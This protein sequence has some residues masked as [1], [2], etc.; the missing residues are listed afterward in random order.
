MKHINVQVIAVAAAVLAAASVAAQ[1]PLHVTKAEGE[2]TVAGD[3]FAASWRADR[4]WQIASVQVEDYAGA[5]N[6]GGLRNDIAGLGAVA[7]R[8][9]GNTYLACEGEA[10]APEIV[11]Q[12][13]DRLTF[14]VI[15]RPRAMDGAICPL[16]LAQRFTV[17]GEGAV[18]C[19][20]EV[21]APEDAAE[22]T[23]DGIEVGMTLA[24]DDLAHLRW[25]WKH[26][27]RGE[28][29]LTREATLEDPRYLRVLGT[30]VGRERP[31][32]NQIEM[33]LEER[34]PLAGDSDSGM[35][36]QV[37]DD[38]G[39]NKRFSWLIG[40]P[41]T[42]GP[43][44]TYSNRFGLALGH[45][46][47]ND[48]AIGQ[49]IAHWQEGN[50]N[51][52][53]YPSDSAIEAMA[54]C[55]VTIN[56]LHLYWY[57][58]P[59]YN[60]FDEAD[61]RRWIA[62]CHERGIKC[63]VYA[64]PTDKAGISGINPEWVQ[65]LD[66]DGIY[67]DF[68]ATH[69][70]SERKY[71]MGRDF[72][73]AFPAMATVELTRHFREAVGP[74]GIIISHSGGYAPDAFFHLNLNAYLPGEAGVQGALLTDP[75]GAAYH[76]GMAYAVVHPWCEYEPFQTRHG[77]AAYCAM[78]GFPHIL[79]G[80]GTHQDNN[81]HRSVYR[82]AKFALP[83]WQMLS[84]I[85]MDRETT[86]YTAATSRAAWTDQEPVRCC[87]YLRSPDLALVTASNL[88][89]A[90]E[91]TLSLDAGLLGLSG[92]Y[93]VIRLA[94]PDIEHF[95]ATE[96]GQWS[97]GEIPLGRMATDD[98]MGLLL[99]RGETPEHTAR[100]LARIETLVASFSDEQA[101]TV[102]DGLAAESSPGAVTL[103]WQP[104][105]DDNHVV[106]HRLYRG[107]EG[108]ELEL[109]AETE[110][111]TG[112][113]DYTAP[114][115]EQVSYAVS[116]VDVAGNESARSPVVTIAT[117]GG[118][119]AGDAIE[120]AVG[121]WKADG[122][123][124]RQGTERVPATEAGDTIEFAPRTAQ[125]VRAW[126]TGGLGNHGSAH[127]IEMTVRDAA[128]RAIKPVAVSSIGS[129]PG[130]PDTDAADGITDKESNGWWSDRT[131]SLPAWVAFDLG[132]PREV[133]SVW[134]LTFWDDTRFYDY[135]IQV[136][137]DG[138]EWR[139][140]GTGASPARN[141]RAFADVAFADGTAS[142]TTLETD[143]ERAGG[144]LLFRCSDESNGY[145]LTL[146]PRWD[147]NLV[148][149]KLVDGKLHRLAGAFFPFSIHNPIPHR[150][151]A[152]C[153]GSTIRCYCDGRLVMEVEDETFTS[154]RAGV[155]VP[156]G[157][158]LMFMNLHSAA[159][160]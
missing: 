34:K 128:G 29:D 73:R 15:A 129:D 148:L 149:D 131:K 1:Q 83:Y 150:L 22:V 26:T 89:E 25:H 45:L 124:L 82:A 123:W 120:P 99:V 52:M 68:G 54:E 86:L 65:G 78:G 76:S 47:Q 14:E 140:V 156:S 17:F 117:A 10:T 118:A 81:Y 96:V 135:S 88:G 90:C 104:A 134:L 59:A 112:Y 119:L 102:P 5:W 43:G 37:S 122:S 67:F 132:G 60:V 28:Q 136:S 144:G 71:D 116:A 87:V 61:M 74:E 106:E 121:V 100:Q 40:G 75:R 44:F 147:G 39:G 158:R 94:G 24:T 95:A 48:N 66:L 103:D 36:C 49:R 97:G 107:F 50:A 143:P 63:I 105:T 101:P 151:E 32:T 155:I 92:S 11:E 56:V 125:W 35:T 91:P 152:E 20:F 2:L 33:C 12:T 111:A 16:E 57:A 77:A 133:A 113:R 62:T 51:L 138:Q 9:D 79:F 13:S 31:Y 114:M 42:A 146:E 18:F 109:L 30:T 21:R 137:D 157:R 64:T 160:P 3:H 154:G 6:V 142:V 23:L 93:R 80:R 58:W 84:V 53:T 55:G 70:L 41:V 38:T 69:V 46:R 159:R 108:G 27:W 19:D 139:D 130:H 115:G 72:S 153:Q 85:P 126:F 7:V 4:G 145:S 110:E 8:C 141:A 127:V 98:Y